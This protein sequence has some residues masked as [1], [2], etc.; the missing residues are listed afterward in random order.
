MAYTVQNIF[1]DQKRASDYSITFSGE[2]VIYFY[3]NGNCRININSSY[4]FQNITLAYSTNNGSTYT[5][6]TNVGK[7]SSYYHHFTVG[8]TAPYW[9]KLVFSMNG[10][11]YNYYIKI[12][13]QTVT[14]Y[15]TFAFSTG[16]SNT[17][18]LSNMRLYN[19]NANY[20]YDDVTSPIAK[21]GDLTDR[22]SKLTEVVYYYN[23][24]DY[25][26]CLVDMDYYYRLYSLVDYTSQSYVHNQAVKYDDINSSSYTD[27]STLPLL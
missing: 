22:T 15:F 17:N 9:L 27:V 5:N 26:G 21:S 14:R 8:T 11:G 10:T 23:Y 12:G 6:I 24:G 16:S 7:N 18:S 20:S 25:S 13:K 3:R 1:R 4:T 2:N 19:S